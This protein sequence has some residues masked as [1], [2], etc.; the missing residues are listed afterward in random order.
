MR[1]YDLSVIGK[2]EVLI[3]NV[4]IRMLGTWAFNYNFHVYKT[5]ESF[6]IFTF[7]IICTFK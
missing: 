2:E 4:N 5:W 3:F 7:N 6:L 1:R